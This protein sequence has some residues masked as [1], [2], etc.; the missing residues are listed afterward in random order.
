MDTMTG[1]V[2]VPID[3]VLS[4][5][6]S[7]SRSDRHWLVERIAEQERREEVEE[8][9]SLEAIATTDS[10]WKE[11]SDARLASA[12]LRFHKNWGGEK[13]PVEIANEL[14]QGAEMVNDVETW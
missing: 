1:T 4:L 10:A 9:E 7:M 13:D 14:R 6:N 8:K 12:L 11:E 2:P 5:L 3:V